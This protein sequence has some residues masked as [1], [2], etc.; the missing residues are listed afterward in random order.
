MEKYGVV[1]E[2][3]CANCAKRNDELAHDPEKTYCTLNTVSV[4]K[5]G[6]CDKHVK[7]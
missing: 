6:V 4:K 5:T 1:D 2:K 7:E 3:T